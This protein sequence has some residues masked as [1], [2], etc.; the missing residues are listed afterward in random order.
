MP[1]GLHRRDLTVMTS[2]RSALQVI[3]RPRQQSG[4]CTIRQIYERTQYLQRRGCSV[5]LMWVP[6]E[7]ED[8]TLKALAKAAA[9]RAAM[10]GET[11]DE[12]PYQARSTKLR[13]AKV[14]QQQ[15]GELP[16][17]VGKYSKR[18]DAALPGRHTRALYDQLER[19]ESDILVQLRTGMARL[20][21]FLHRIGVVESD[22]CECGKAPETMEH[23]LFRCR[24]W[25]AQRE[26]FLDCSSGKI[27]N[28]S[29]FLG[30]KA[31]SDDDKWKPAT[32]AVKAVIKFA[33][34]TGRL[35]REQRP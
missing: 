18:V 12:R 9:K 31:P 8:F 25:T 17:G 26:I 4:Q 14:A 29:Y 28:L 16:E 24:R 1:A 7:N 33:M 30:G 13:L 20:N 23:F 10:C 3:R 35:A 21:G 27:G 22:L 11:P 5:S 6:A 34:A 32:R 15:L 19:R 2:N